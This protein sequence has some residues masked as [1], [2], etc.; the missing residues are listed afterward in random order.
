MPAKNLDF[1]C[2]NNSKNDRA[3]VYVTIF[4]LFCLKKETTTG[5]TTGTTTTANYMVSHLS[6][7]RD[8]DCKN[9]VSTSV[10]ILE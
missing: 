4:S 10:L 5:T 9:S 2:K 6:F 7:C 1:I 8:L 3:E